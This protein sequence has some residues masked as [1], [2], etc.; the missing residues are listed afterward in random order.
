M[1]LASE[2]D[3]GLLVPPWV[4]EVEEA[5]GASPT[6]CCGGWRGNGWEGRV[7]SR[8]QVRATYVLLSAVGSLAESGQPAALCLGFL[9]CHTAMS[10]SHVTLSSCVGVP[11]AL[12][13]RRLR[14]QQV[15]QQVT[16]TALLNLVA[17]GRTLPGLLSHLPSTQSSPPAHRPAWGQPTDCAHASAHGPPSAGCRG[18]PR[19]ARWAACGRGEHR[20]GRGHP[21]I[22]PHSGR[23]Q[24]QNKRIKET[25]SFLA[26]Q[27]GH[28]GQ[29]T[30]GFTCFRGCPGCQQGGSGWFQVSA[31]LKPQGAA[32]SCSVPTLKAEGLPLFADRTLPA[33]SL[34]HRHQLSETL[35]SGWSKGRADVLFMP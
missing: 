2:A 7:H 28:T 33:G 4:C 27:P 1:G 3:L 24:S 25:A 11:G 21:P 34:L 6:G 35:G 31:C 9:I 19:S 17:A 32:A 18:A 12:L 5:L 15:P 20:G 30:W 13:P 22:W 14:P 23:Q 10:L 8:C 29:R 16:A 26:W